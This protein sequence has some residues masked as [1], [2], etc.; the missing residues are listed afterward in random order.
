MAKSPEVLIEDAH[1]LANHNFLR[2]GEFFGLDTRGDRLDNKQALEEVLEW[3][4]NKSESDDIIDVLLHIRSIERNLVGD[5]TE[6]RINKIRKYIALE[7]DQERVD[8]EKA[9]LTGQEVNDA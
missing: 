8:K 1:L 9:L 2:L 7:K 6:P 3:A 5:S 4:K